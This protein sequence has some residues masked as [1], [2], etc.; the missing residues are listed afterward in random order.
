MSDRRASD[1]GELAVR[2]RQ[3]ADLAAL[4]EVLSRVQRETGYPVNLPADPV[5]WLKSSRTRASWVA[6]LSGR[7]I[8]Q[9]SRAAVERDHAR[10][11]WTTA[12][13]LPA[14]ALAVVKRLFVDPGATRVGA[15]RLLLET[16]MADAH[17]L[18]LVPVLDV[19][20]S[21]RRAKRLYERS[22]FQSVGQLELTWSGLD[23][24][25]LAECY[26]GPPPPGRPAGGPSS[27]THSARSATR[28]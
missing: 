7:V 24:V 16:V 13:G 2:P 9:V 18:G 11:T 3:E 21:S 25:F 28:R 12:T 8:G 17:R 23:G 4:V 20:A 14:E 27:A 5:A 26:V 1:G 10:E 19:D 6:T 15:G 22:G